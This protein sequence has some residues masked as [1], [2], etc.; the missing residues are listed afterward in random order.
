MIAG[1]APDLAT[2]EA[3]V[4]RG[5]VR[6][7]AFVDGALRLA[8][9]RE[10]SPREALTA[11]HDHLAARALEAHT[12]TRDA[13]RGGSLR[14]ARLRSHLDALAPELR[15]HTVEE[16]LGIA[17]PP[18]AEPARE[19]EII[20]YAPSGY[21][22]IVHA[23]DVTGLGEGG[24]LLDVGAGLGKV[25][26]L[27]AL[28]TGARA[29]GIERDGPLHRASVDAARALGLEHDVDLREGDARVLDAG[30]VDVVFMYLPCTGSAL[31]AVLARLG[32]R[33][34][35]HLCG[36]SLDLARHPSL[37]SIERPRGWLQIYGRR[38]AL[39]S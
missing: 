22:E 30:D 12:A 18:L 28:L 26:L 36:G 25:V 39:H 4:E 13:I 19:P 8:W 38:D 10:S 20:P 33:R 3:L 15:E 24:V 9:A 37:V 35:R 27:A 11:L 14:G 34:F 29:I 32:T 5:D 6:D 23:L 7:R 17:Y 1:E 21:A 16:L 31:E 2:L